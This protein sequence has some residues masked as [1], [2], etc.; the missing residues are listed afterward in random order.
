MEIVVKT[1]GGGVFNMVLDEDK[2]VPSFI[3]KDNRVSYKVLP[4]FN[5]ISIRINRTDIGLKEFDVKN[6]QTVDIIINMS[7][8]NDICIENIEVDETSSSEVEITWKSD[9]M[10]DEIQFCFGLLYDK[11]VYQLDRIF[12]GNDDIIHTMDYPMLSDSSERAMVYG[13]PVFSQS[14]MPDDHNLDFSLVVKSHGIQIIPS[15]NPVDIKNELKNR[16]AMH[17]TFID[18][19]SWIIKMLRKIWVQGCVV[20]VLFAIDNEENISDMFET[21]IRED[22]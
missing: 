18:L 20:D 16:R 6:H 17:N 8:K 19:P 14:E 9:S 11:Y 21:M 4:S 5:S 15:I 7:Q 12:D 2:K 10:V 22:D 1:I 13:F 3:S